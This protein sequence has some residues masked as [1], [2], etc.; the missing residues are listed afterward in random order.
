MAGTERGTRRVREG[1]E[2]AGNGL[3]LVG[4]GARLSGSP[5]TCRLTAQ[6]SFTPLLDLPGYRVNLEHESNSRPPILK[7]EVSAPIGFVAENGAVERIFCAPAGAEV[8][9]PIGGPQP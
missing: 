5:S 9:R 3:D 8:I 6:S 4:G 2:L 1:V 7:A